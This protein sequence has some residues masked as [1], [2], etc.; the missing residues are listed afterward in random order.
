MGLGE[1]A[2]A[3]DAVDEHDGYTYGEREDGVEFEFVEVADYQQVDDKQFQR[4]VEDFDI[5][6]DI[7]LLVGDD[8]GV[9]RGLGDA[10]HGAQD[11]ALVHPMRGLHASF[12][13]YEFVAEEPQANC[14]GK[15]EHHQRDADVDDERAGEGVG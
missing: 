3:V 6:V 15:H 12:G 7:H 8:A 2:D 9:V 13:D 5:G 1:A 14:L 4:D 10:E 11:G